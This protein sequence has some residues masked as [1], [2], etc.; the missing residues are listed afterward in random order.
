[1]FTG[2]NV[3]S[4]DK[5]EKVELWKKRRCFIARDFQRKIFQI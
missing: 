5:G 2:F 3:R 1:M 4:K